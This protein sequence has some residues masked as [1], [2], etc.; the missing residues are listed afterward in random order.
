MEILGIWAS[1]LP[2]QKTE[3]GWYGPACSAPYA[4]NRGTLLAL[5]EVARQDRFNQFEYEIRPLPEPLATQVFSEE[6][7]GLWYNGVPYPP[8][9]G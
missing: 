4:G 1:P 8:R 2:G 3:T 9:T 5:I 7:L 6:L